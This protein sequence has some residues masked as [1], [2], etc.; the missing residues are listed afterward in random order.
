MQGFQLCVPVL[1]IYFIWRG[2]SIRKRLKE[3]A[4]VGAG[5]EAL[6][7]LF[8][9]YIL[10]LV[11]IKLFPIDLSTVALGTAVP[12]VS[13]RPFETIAQT[14]GMTQVPLSTRVIAILSE[15]VTYLPIGLL[16]PLM[17]KELSNYQS[18]VTTSI[19]F[20]LCIDA[21]RIIETMF[22]LAVMTVAFDDIIFAVVG[23][24]I[25]W[26]LFL[27]VRTLI[28]R[29]WDPDFRRTV[30][31]MTEAEKAELLA[32]EEAEWFRP[33]DDGAPSDALD[34]EDE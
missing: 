1:I 20:C 30:P 19:V 31:I 17:S 6:Y 28:R 25:G 14:L 3:G 32:D 9:L 34:D 33:V 22:N 26:F 16:P 18:V 5:S 8:A 13:L 10:E 4:E 23:A 7:L 29:R 21:L 27:A 11:S 12:K 2:V 15:L 24:T